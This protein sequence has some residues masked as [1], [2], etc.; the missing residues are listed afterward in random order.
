M[1]KS[2]LQC[3]NLTLYCADLFL[4]VSLLFRNILHEKNK[5]PF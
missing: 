5:L 1:S 3:R 4:F 2:H